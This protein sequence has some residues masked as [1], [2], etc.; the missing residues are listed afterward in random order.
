MFSVGK[1]RQQSGKSPTL[2]PGLLLALPHHLQAVGVGAARLHQG[3]AVGGGPAR[4]AVA[5][6]EGAG[7]GGVLGH[8][9]GGGEGLAGE[10]VVLTGLAGVVGLEA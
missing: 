6:R 10:V 3:R 7:A 9:D 1:S 5:A 8:Q 4:Q 2:S